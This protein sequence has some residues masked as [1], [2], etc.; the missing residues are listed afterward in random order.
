M[1][2]F[3]LSKM[4]ALFLLGLVAMT[5]ASPIATFN[6]ASAGADLATV[7]SVVSDSSQT[8]VA[9]ATK[10]EEAKNCF[11]FCVHTYCTRQCI[12]DDAVAAYNASG[13]LVINETDLQANSTISVTVSH[14]QLQNPFLYHCDW[15][16]GTCWTD[17]ALEAVNGTETAIED[18]PDIPYKVCREVCNMDES[19]CGLVCD[20]DENGKPTEKDPEKPISDSKFRC[21]WECMFGQCWA[22]CSPVVMTGGSDDVSTASTAAMKMCRWECYFGQCHACCPPP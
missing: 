11:W 16:S 8:S 1:A 21:H 10:R 14:A 7:E 22:V 6:G 12:G 9:P 13:M 17:P 2:A 20:E 19:L 3:K 5:A 4:L 18:I 15:A